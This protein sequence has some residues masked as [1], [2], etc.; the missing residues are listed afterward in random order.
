MKETE[1]NIKEMK[2]R[3]VTVVFLIAM[4]S[5]LCLLVQILGMRVALSTFVTSINVINSF[6]ISSFMFLLM[7]LY[8]A[9]TRL[10]MNAMGKFITFMACASF[11]MTIAGIVNM[12]LMNAQLLIVSLIISAFYVAASFVVQDDLKSGQ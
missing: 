8:L 3:L 2:E 5:V 9:F 12:I 4:Y 1:N 7:I 6:A 11:S 10:D